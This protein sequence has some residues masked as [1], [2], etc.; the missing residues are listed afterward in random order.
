MRELRTMFGAHKARTWHRL[1][2]DARN[3]HVPKAANP[4]AV[5]RECLMAFEAVRKDLLWQHEP[6]TMQSQMEVV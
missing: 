3:V 1:M 6:A 4:F 2:A 5:I